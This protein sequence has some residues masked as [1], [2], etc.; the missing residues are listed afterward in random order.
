MGATPNILCPEIQ[1]S[2]E[3]FKANS[4]S[5]FPTG[6]SYSLFFCAQFRI[7]TNEIY[8]WNIDGLS[9]YEILVVLRQ[10]QMAATSYL[11]EGYN[12]NAVQLLLTGFTGKLKF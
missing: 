5:F 11:M 4:E 6:N 3:Y 12:R 1:K 2:F 7:P 10:M 8:S 9:E